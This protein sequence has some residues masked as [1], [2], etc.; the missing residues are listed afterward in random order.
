MTKDQATRQLQ[1]LH[2]RRVYVHPMN[3]AVFWAVIAGGAWVG[4]MAFDFIDKSGTSVAVAFVAAWLAG[5]IYERRKN[6][7][8]IIERDETMQRP[9]PRSLGRR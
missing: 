8:M 1:M 5:Y 6:R 4:L 7:R 3:T 2:A 9:W